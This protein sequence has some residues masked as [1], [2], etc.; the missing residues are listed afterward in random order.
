MPREPLIQSPDMA[1]GVALLEQGG[2][3]CARNLARRVRRWAG[4]NTIP[5]YGQRV[6]RRVRGRAG[7]STGHSSSAWRTGHIARSKALAWA[8]ATALPTSVLRACRLAARLT[9]I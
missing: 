2:E 4:R 7:G 8:S 1:M 6:A 3:I 5:R 9:L